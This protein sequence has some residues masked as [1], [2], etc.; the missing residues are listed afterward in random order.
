MLRTHAHDFSV[1]LVRRDD[2]RSR[3][4]LFRA[5]DMIFLSRSSW[6]TWCGIEGDFGCGGLLPSSCT[7]RR[8]PPTVHAPTKDSPAVRG[9]VRWMLRG[10]TTVK[11]LTAVHVG[12][13]LCAD[14]WRKHPPWLLLLVAV[15]V[16]SWCTVLPSLSVCLCA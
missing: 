8:V 10:E 6:L 14:A 1:A 13:A 7:C 4:V 16:C 3:F 12:V 11:R 15:A 9:D 2:G 5:K